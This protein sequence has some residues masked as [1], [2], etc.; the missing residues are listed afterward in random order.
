MPLTRKE[1]KEAAIGGGAAAVAAPFTPTRVKMPAS[2]GGKRAGESAA[3]TGRASTADLRQAYRGMGGRLGND[4]HVARL[5]HSMGRGG[6]N[7]K[8]D[9][10]IDIK[11]FA[12]GETMVTGGH[13]RIAAA[14][15]VGMHDMPVRVTESKAK[16]PYS[17]VPLYARGK[18]KRDVLA[19]RKPGKE[20][21]DDTIRSMAQKKIP[22]A[23]HHVNTVKSKVEESIQAAK[24]PKVAIPVAAGAALVGGGAA[25]RSK[26]KIK[27][28]DDAKSLARAKRQQAN[29]S[30]GSALL[31]FSAMGTKAGS[32]AYKRAVKKPELAT[33]KNVKYL[34][35]AH[36][37]DKASVGILAAGAGVGGVSGLRFAHVQRSEAKKLEQD[38]VQKNAFGVEVSKGKHSAPEPPKAEQF[39]T[40][41]KQGAETGKKVLRQVGGK[42]AGW[43]AKHPYASTAA[44]GAGLGAAALAP[45]I[46]ATE[47][48]TRRRVRN[49]TSGVF[50]K[51][52]GFDP[53]RRRQNRQGMYTGAMAAGA[54]G[55]GGMA[56]NPGKLAVQAH[57]DASKATKSAKKVKLVAV[58]DRNALKAGKYGAGAAALGVGAAAMAHHSRN[59][60][61]TYSGWFSQ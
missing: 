2:P 19:S 52:R 15:M 25:Y 48:I 10:P 39:K 20:L 38:K 34:R 14:E 24:K 33:A 43:A 49:A 11:R 37:L 44:I 3:A 26:D 30:T 17:I 21:S 60:G 46:L 56:Y 1:K 5:A 27:K 58:R 8:S 4:T 50:G 31:G 59:G 13:H 23:A 12:S 51:A 57:Q 40:N 9:S 53:E 41:L 28:A 42:T 35:R 32:F 18:Y 45:G 7:Y 36:H 47:G 29:L 61:K 16:H 55:M 54:A 6:K 22:R